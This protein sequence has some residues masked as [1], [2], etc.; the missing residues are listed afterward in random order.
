MARPSAN[1]DA[2]NDV[3]EEA[4]ELACDSEEVLVKFRALCD[5]LLENTRQRKHRLSVKGQL[6]GWPHAR[7]ELLRRVG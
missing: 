7:P 3:V 2:V 5:S 1:Q 4:L 6:V